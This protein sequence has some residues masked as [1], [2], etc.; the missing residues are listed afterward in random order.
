M[1]PTLRVQDLPPPFFMPPSTTSIPPVVPTIEEVEEVT[2]EVV[3]DVA[4][5]EDTFSRAEVE[6]LLQQ[7]C[8]DIDRKMEIFMREYKCKDCESRPAVAATPSF[9]S[10]LIS[11]MMPLAAMAG[12]HLLLG[13]MR[14][15]VPQRVPMQMMQVQRPLQQSSADASISA[16]PQSASC[17]SGAISSS[18]TSAA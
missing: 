4:V 1:N 2:E 13:V 14:P 7:Y 8:D 15:T 3:E 16:L 12:A 5:V 17:V 18:L 11:G 9:F 6:E 10:T